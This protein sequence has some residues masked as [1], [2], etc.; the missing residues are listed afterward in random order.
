[1]RKLVRR[2]VLVL[3]TGVP[4]AVMVGAATVAEAVPCHTMACSSDRRLKKNIRP[5]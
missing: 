4:V 3:S 5:I 1:M 2:L